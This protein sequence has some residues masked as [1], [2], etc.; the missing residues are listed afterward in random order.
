MGSSLPPCPQNNMAGWDLC[1]GTFIENRDIFRGELRNNQ[2][3]GFG[4]CTW[5]NRDL[6]KGN[7]ERGK[8]S[9]NGIFSYSGRSYFYGK[10]DNGA[11]ISLGLKLAPHSYAEL[12][13]H[14]PSEI[15]NF[16]NSDLQG[17][18]PVLKDVF[19]AYPGD[20]GRGIQ[21][22]LKKAGFYHI[23]ADGIL[24]RDSL[25]AIMKY[26]SDTLGNNKLNNPDFAKTLLSSL[27]VTK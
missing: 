26:A 27:T 25:I 24:G 6:C 5:N 13:E 4:K 23:P 9:S 2:K 3:N 1:G 22:K 8:L 19:N 7:W 16:L 11:K 17:S 10:F 15:K 18:F 20:N 21:L 14:H 12:C